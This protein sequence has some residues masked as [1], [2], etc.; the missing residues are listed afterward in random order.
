MPNDIASEVTLN[1]TEDAAGRRSVAQPPAIRVRHGQSIRFKR[2]VVPP[3]LTVT[4]VF[5]EPQFF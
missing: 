2:G 3:D 4:I 5:T 1:Y